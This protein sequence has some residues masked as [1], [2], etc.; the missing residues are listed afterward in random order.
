MLSLFITELIAADNTQ[1]LLSNEA[2]W[3]QA[4][5]NQSACPAAVD[6]KIAFPVM[7]GAPADTIAETVPQELRSDARRDRRAQPAAHVSQWPVI[8]EYNP[9]G[10]RLVDRTNNSPASDTILL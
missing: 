2:V 6:L 4:I 8:N 9:S 1:V 10:L 7:A 5:L 3:G